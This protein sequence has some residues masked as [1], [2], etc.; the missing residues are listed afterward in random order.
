VPRSDACFAFETHKTRRIFPDGCGRSCPA[1][2]QH[3]QRSNNRLHPVHGFKIRARCSQ[4]F[5]LRL[6]YRSLTAGGDQRVSDCAGHVQHFLQSCEQRMDS[7]GRLEFRDRRK[8]STRYR[9][10]PAS[11]EL[12][13]ARR[14][15]S[16]MLCTVPGA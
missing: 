6:L 16:S 1:P 9:R 11:F 3:T 4:M 2:I 12:H 14:N 13:K 8:G 5:V 7:I 15:S 10:N